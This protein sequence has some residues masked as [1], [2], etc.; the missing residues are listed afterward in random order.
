[1]LLEIIQWAGMRLFMEWM[2]REWQ[3]IKRRHRNWQR[4]YESFDV[5]RRCYN[6]CHEITDKNKI[7]EV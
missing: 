7:G 3:P 5:F 4:N 6:R 2:I 1:M